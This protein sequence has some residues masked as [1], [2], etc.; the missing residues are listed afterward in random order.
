M[1]AGDGFAPPS[2]ELMRLF[3]SLDLPAQSGGNDWTRTSNTLLMK[4]E[5]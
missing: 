3:G 5:D 1:D 4:Q 2:R